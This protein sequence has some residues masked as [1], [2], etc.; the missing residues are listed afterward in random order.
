MSFEIREFDRDD[1]LTYMG[2]GRLPNEQNPYLKPL[3]LN[4]PCDM[5]DNIDPCEG[6]LLICGDDCEEGIF[7]AFNI[8]HPTNGILHTQRSVDSLEVALSIA[9]RLPAEFDSRYLERFLDVYGFPPLDY[10]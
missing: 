10:C 6:D 8:C 7:L 2:A 1:H 3:I 5:S 9:A 4:K